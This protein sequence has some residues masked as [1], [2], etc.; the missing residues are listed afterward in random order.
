MAKPSE[1]VY[2]NHY[3]EMF[4]ENHKLDL[5][6]MKSQELLKINRPGGVNVTSTGIYFTYLESHTADIFRTQKLIA[7]SILEFVYAAPNL[8]Y[9]PKISWLNRQSTNT[10]ACRGEN[11]VGNR[12]SNRWIRRLTGTRWWMVGWDNVHVNIRDLIY[13][14]Y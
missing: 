7:T 2:I 9:S 1:T 10:R 6:T 13:A 5:A 3:G 14:S 11:S 12:G 4:I 8:K